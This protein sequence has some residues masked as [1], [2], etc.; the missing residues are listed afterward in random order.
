VEKE[1]VLANEVDDLIFAMRP[2][3]ELPAKINGKLKY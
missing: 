2:R 3:I 1:T